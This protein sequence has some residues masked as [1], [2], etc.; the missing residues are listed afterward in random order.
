LKLLS[1]EEN[2]VI[3]EGVAENPNTPVEILEVLSQDKYNYVRIK[4]IQN[5]NY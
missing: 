4:A 3:R 5:P 1:K 2:S